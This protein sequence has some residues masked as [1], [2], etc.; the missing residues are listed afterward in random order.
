MLLS[1]RTGLVSRRAEREGSFRVLSQA[2]S[3]FIIRNRDGLKSGT[4]LPCID[5]TVSLCGV[6][7]PEPHRLLAGAVFAPV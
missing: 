7:M 6:C 4:L 2:A 5:C 3:S 1:G